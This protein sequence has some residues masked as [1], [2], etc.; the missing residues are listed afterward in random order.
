MMKRIFVIDG[1]LVPAFVLTVATGVGLHWAGHGDSHAV[2]HAW[3]V[4]HTLVGFVFTAA[5]AVHIGMH[6]VWYRSLVRSRRLGRK[7]RVTAMVSVAF[8]VL[9]LTGIVLLWTEG[10]NTPLGLW[11]YKV[12]LLSTM[13]FTGHIL[14]RMP[15]LLQGCRRRRSAV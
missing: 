7:S 15:A 11:H 5:G 3:A 8:V 14:R 10:A 9:T 1:L 4:A 2:W 13:L 12:G 6:W